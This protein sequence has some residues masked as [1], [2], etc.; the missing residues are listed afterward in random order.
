M[1]AMG[2]AGMNES[3]LEQRLGVLEMARAW[4]PRVISKLEATI[5]GAAD[6]ELFRFNPIKH[7]ARSGMAEGEA[8]ALFLH[9]ARAGLFDMEWNLVCGSCAHMVQ[10]L[11]S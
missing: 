9:G 6:E 8:I 2:N 4:S 3:E 10:S 1:F 11:D 5:R 7:A